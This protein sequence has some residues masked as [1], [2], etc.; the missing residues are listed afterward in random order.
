MATKNSSKVT[1]DLTQVPVESFRT[2]DIPCGVFFVG[3]PTQKGKSKLYIKGD[4]EIIELPSFTK[5]DNYWGDIDQIYGY[6][7]VDVTISV[8]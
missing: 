4:D 6:R 7:V 2:H 8:K 3:S 5:L 1:V